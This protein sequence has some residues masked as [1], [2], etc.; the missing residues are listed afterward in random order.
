MKAG[1]GHEEQDA[2]TYAA[3][4][5]DYLKYDLCSARRIYE[6]TTEDIRGLYQKMGD[7]LSRTGRPIVFSL[8]E[9]GL[10]DVWEWGPD[11][12]GNLWRATGDIQDNWASMDRLGFAQLDIAAFAKPG[13]WNDPDMLEIG[14]GGMTVDEYRTHM[15]LWSLLSAPL[16]AGND[17]V[18]MTD[19]TK[20][21]LTNPDVIA[22]DQ[23]SLAKPVQ[24]ISADGNAVVLIRQLHG[25]AAAIGL[26]NRGTHPRE[27]S[28]RWDSL[29]LGS[30]W[31]RKHFV[32]LICGNMKW[33]R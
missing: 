18:N 24:T 2:R 33:S 22:I 31:A 12:S 6:Q 30:A 5:I 15:S 20:S 13:H 21:I 7:A 17:V 10:G 3:W 25:N 26:F 27:I 16:I 19:E 23:D 14:N 9:Y 32:R 28:V 29:H 11:V 1:T 4:G 8:C